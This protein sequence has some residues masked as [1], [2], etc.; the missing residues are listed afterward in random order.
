MMEAHE[1]SAEDQSWLLKL[2]RATLES[3]APHGDAVPLENQVIH[4]EMPPSAVEKRGVFVSL[5]KAGRLRGCIGYIEPIVPLY[6]AVIDNAVNAARR[7]P[8]FDPLG[9]DE[10]G[11]V[12]IEISVMT[13]PRKITDIGEIEVGRHGLIASQG[14]SRGLLLPQVATEYGWDRETFLNHVCQKAGLRPDA[15]RDGKVDFEVFSAQVFG[16]KDFA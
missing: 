13:V 4:G 7:D 15:W 9:L 11:E 8:R 16:E 1:L 5:H 12:D 3:L 6:Q 2:A 10:V 14:L